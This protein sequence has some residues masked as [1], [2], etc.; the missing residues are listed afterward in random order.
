MMT[1]KKKLIIFQFG[2]HL[3]QI[4]FTLKTDADRK[5]CLE[6]KNFFLP[7]TGNTICIP[8][9]LTIKFATPHISLKLTFMSSH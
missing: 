8:F 7:T 3:N 1:N 5:N 2:T 9:F 4:I 6:V